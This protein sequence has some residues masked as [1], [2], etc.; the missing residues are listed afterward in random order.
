M[1]VIEPLAG[2]AA[3]RYY[4]DGLVMAAAGSCDVVT[5]NKGL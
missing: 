3:C 1:I 4:Y 5:G 2:I